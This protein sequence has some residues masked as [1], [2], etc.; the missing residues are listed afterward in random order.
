VYIISRLLLAIPM[1]LILLSV[2][3]VVLRVMPGDP[4][5]AIVGPK[6]P[7]SVKEKLRHELGLD[8]PLWEQYVDY[9]SGLLKG[10]MGTSLYTHRPVFEE[11]M[12]HFPATLE[13]TICSMIV[14]IVVGIFTGAFGAR[15]RNTPG[16]VAVRVYG[17]MIYAFFIPWFAM[18]LKLVF[19]VYLKWLPSGSRIEPWAT[20]KR[21]TGL[22]LI[23]SLLTGNIVAFVSA[24]RHL[25]LPSMTLGL[26]LSGIFTRMTRGNLIE[27]LRRDFITAA[28]ARGIPE[29][30]VIYG[31]ALK[32]A[33]I[34]I[35]TM[36][37][38]EFA[39]L[40]AGAVL[41]ETSFA[42]PGIGTFLVERIAYRDYTAVQG[43][44]VFYALL[45]VLVNLIVDVIYAYIDPRIRY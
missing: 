16:D 12:D 1:I 21:I 22:Y 5:D 31:H 42:W 8:K 27:I 18:L 43:V 19:S 2:V 35:I 25:I 9:L 38:M 39:L 11:I 7:E 26:V 4:V 34:P 44:V 45:V 28:R 23:D 30:R 20:P 17:I 36:F 29:N 40:L 24:I 32:N 33:L 14:A 37:G 15:R 6:A 13:L 3:F 10:D 41:T